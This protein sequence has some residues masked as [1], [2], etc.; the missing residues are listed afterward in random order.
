VPGIVKSET[1]EGTSYMCI[2]LGHCVDRK[3]V[4]LS[5]H[6]VLWQALLLTVFSL[7]LSKCQYMQLMSSEM[8]NRPV[9]S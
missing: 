1:V 9:H 6:R 5:P 2:F 3:W 7:L 4:Q 8:Q